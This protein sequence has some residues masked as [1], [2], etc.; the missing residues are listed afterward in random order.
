MP[1]F[2]SIISHLQQ[3]WEGK[4]RKY[5]AISVYMLEQ[6]KREKKVVYAYEE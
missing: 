2:P 4:G 6:E 5:E 1:Q 3:S